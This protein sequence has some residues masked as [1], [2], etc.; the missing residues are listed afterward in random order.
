M[1]M[2]TAGRPSKAIGTL[3]GPEDV[4]HVSHVLLLSGGLVVSAGKNLRPA[5]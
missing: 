2:G 4:L 1:F 5:L 3:D